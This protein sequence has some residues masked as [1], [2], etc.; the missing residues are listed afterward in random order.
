MQE[1]TLICAVCGYQWD[2]ECKLV[3]TYS[4]S[5][6][7]HIWRPC[8]FEKICPVCDLS[9]VYQYAPEREEF[10][11]DYYDGLPWY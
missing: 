6:S 11:G 4:S 8:T 10:G 1:T 2:E 9:I 7:P 5:T 3:K